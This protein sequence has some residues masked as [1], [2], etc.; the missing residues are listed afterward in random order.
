[1]AYGVN[2]VPYS[3]SVSNF[4]EARSSRDDEKWAYVIIAHEKRTCIFR[5]DCE[6]RWG[7]FEVRMLDN[8][9]SRDGHNIE[10]AEPE[11]RSRK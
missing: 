3:R 2:L 5:I 6:V 11:H 1:M 4:C 8:D 10:H 7:D 9:G